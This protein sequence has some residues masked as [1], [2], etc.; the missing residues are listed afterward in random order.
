MVKLFIKE[1]IGRT[2]P[3]KK[4][5]MVMSRTLSR[6][7]IDESLHFLVLFSLATFVFEAIF[8][9]L[10]MEGRAKNLSYPGPFLCLSKKHGTKRRK[11]NQ[12]GTLHNA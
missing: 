9:K 10:M 6:T 2:F 12:N 8:L 1:A 7:L 5:D 11:V 3:L 4:H